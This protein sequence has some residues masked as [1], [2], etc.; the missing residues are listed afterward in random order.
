MVM[1]V[2]LGQGCDVARC[3]YT[4]MHMQTPRCR[5]DITSYYNVIS[6]YIYNVIFFRGSKRVYQTRRTPWAHTRIHL[7]VSSSPLA[8]MCLFCWSFLSLPPTTE[9]GE[10]RTHTHSTKDGRG[11]GPILDP[12]A[13]TAHT[14]N[15]EEEGE[16]DARQEVSVR[17]RKRRRWTGNRRFWPFLKHFGGFLGRT[18]LPFEVLQFF[19]ELGKAKGAL[20]LYLVGTGITQTTILFRELLYS[21]RHNF[22][23]NY[24]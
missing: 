18:D 9:R 2:N 16:T 12:T 21:N 22:F 11:G 17:K 1:H 24:V 14:H 6:Y 13:T 23:F 8:M 15:K 3:M 19:C 20:S 7:Q 4:R 10:P 5:Q